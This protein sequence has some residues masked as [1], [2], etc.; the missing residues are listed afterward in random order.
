MEGGVRF[1]ASAHAVS[2]EKWRLAEELAWVLTVVE[3]AFSFDLVTGNHIKYQH[4]PW[5]SASLRFTNYNQSINKMLLQ[6]QEPE[7]FPTGPL[8]PQPSPPG[9]S[10]YITSA[11][12]TCFVFFPTS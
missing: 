5:N 8:S 9:P 12:E 3:D 6:K 11:S 10:G 7:A 2:G 4:E 1:S